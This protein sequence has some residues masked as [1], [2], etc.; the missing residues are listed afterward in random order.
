MREI[1]SLMWNRL[2][3]I[4]SIVGEVVGSIIATVFYFTILAP[5]GLISRLST[6][7]MNLK[8]TTNDPHW[9]ERPAVPAE[10]EAAKRQG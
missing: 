10:I 3:I 9:L 7:P 1:L 4:S 2:G 8:S 5:F 6:D